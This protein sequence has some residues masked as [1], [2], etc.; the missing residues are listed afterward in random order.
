MAAFELLSSDTLAERAGKLVDIAFIGAQVPP[1]FVAQAKANLTRALEV[2]AANDVRK[3]ARSSA[4]VENVDL[5]DPASQR[6][7]LALERW[8][9]LAGKTFWITGGGTGY[10]LAVGVALALA[11]AKVALSGRRFGQL[12]AAAEEIRRFRPDAEIETLPLDVTDS[13]AVDAAVARLR[14]RFG[15]VDGLVAAAALSGNPGPLLGMDEKAMRRVLEVNVLGQILPCR[16]VLPAMLT[17]GSGRVV[18]MSSECAWGFPPGLGVYDVSKAAVNGLGP[19]LANE[20]AAMAP[21]ADVQVN[22][23]DPGQARTEMNQG[24]PES[25]FAVCSMVLTLLAQP[26]GG[27][28]GRFFHRDGRHLSYGYVPAW[29]QPLA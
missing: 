29:P 12:R 24:S 6:F 16:A 4:I 5:R 22:V 18:L 25:P 13:K 26:S 11:G 10:G 20:M 21:G 7:G 9:A 19:S 15:A 1:E 8:A 28:T 3:A 17:A 2:Y 14:K 27:P 23:L